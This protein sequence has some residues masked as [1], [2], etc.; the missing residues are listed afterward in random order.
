MQAILRLEMSAKKT[1]YVMVC[2]EGIAPACNAAA[3][4]G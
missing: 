1:A 2:A 3:L 4:L